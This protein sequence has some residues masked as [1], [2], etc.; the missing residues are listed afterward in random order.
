MS[1]GLTFVVYLA[2]MLTIGILAYRRTRDL[3]DYILG[4]RRLGSWVTA[5]T[6]RALKPKRGLPGLEE[7]QNG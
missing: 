7:A 1:T 6:A 5:L 2:A 4:G 3:S